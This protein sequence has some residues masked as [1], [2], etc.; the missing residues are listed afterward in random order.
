MP[1]ANQPSV[2]IT[3]LT[4]ENVKFTIE[5]TDLR[6]DALHISDQCNS[7]SYFTEL[8]PIVFFFSDVAWPMASEEYLS[9]KPQL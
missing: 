9:L 3:E 2:K 8:S 7:L 5:N 4:E 6:W 1:Y